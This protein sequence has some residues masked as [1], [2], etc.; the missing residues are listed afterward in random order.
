MDK[1]I[2]TAAVTGSLT[3]REQNPNLPHTPEEIAKAAVE[4]NDAGAAIVHLHVREPESGR[5]VQDVE[6]F[7]ET[8][9]LIRNQCNVIINTST[10]GA[11][12]MTADERIAIVPGLAAD[13]RVKQEMASLNMGSVNFGIFSRR[14]RA[15]VLDA[16]QLNPWSQLLLYAD[17]MR[18]YGVKPEIEIYEAGMVNNAR[19]LHE[20]GALE[21]PLH[22]QFVLGVLGGM[23]ATVDNL[24]FLKNALPA[25]ST[26]S[27]CTVGLDIFW[28]GAVAIAAGGHVR[29]GLEDCVHISEGLLAESS[30]QM[31]MRIVRLAGEMGRSIATADEARGILRL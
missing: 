26:W 4:A 11:P 19:Y 17:T 20:V 13:P 2:I 7:R 29:V 18:E 24:V 1:L 21:T 30:A 9:Q 5:P 6:L 25:D 3:T 31:V 15:F 16:I 27:L 8:I 23:Q 12:G 22:F 28:L 14:R 10:G